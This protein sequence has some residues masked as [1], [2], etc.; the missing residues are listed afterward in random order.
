MLKAHFPVD[1]FYNEATYD[2]QYG[3]VKRPT[4]KNTSWDIAR[5]EVCAHKWMDVSEANFGFTL[6]NDCKY[7]HSA[8]D[9]GVA[10]TLLK[11]STV[12][13]PEAD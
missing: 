3:N 8:D 13:N 9:N 10:L 4:H 1:V 5:F 7:G 12:P 11:S 6:M 2:I